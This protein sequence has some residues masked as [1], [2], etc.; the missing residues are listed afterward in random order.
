VH[1]DTIRAMPRVRHRAVALAAL[2]ALAACAGPS[3]SDQPPAA[4]APAITPTSPTPTTAGLPTCPPSPPPPTLPDDGGWYAWALIDRC[5]LGEG[6]LGS[7]NAD[8]PLNNTVDVNTTESMIKAWIAAD[9]LRTHEMPPDYRLDQLAAMLRDSDNEATQVIYDTQGGDAA[10]RR[11]IDMCDLSSTRIV[12]GWWSLTTI[13]AADAARLGL[14]L[15]SGLAAGPLWTPWLLDRMREV[16]GEG[17]FGIADALT[18]PA[19]A[20]VAYKNGW[21]VRDGLWHVNCLAIGG[22]WVLAVLTRYPA[23]LGRTH[24]AKVCTDVARTVLAAG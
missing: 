13:S 15:A 14:C 12:D 20:E 10:I 19:R 3:T 18:G 5:Y 2:L 17:A 1:A 11:M 8:P 16:H 9:Y 21:T 24:G 22:R 6:I 7:A 4:P 23:A